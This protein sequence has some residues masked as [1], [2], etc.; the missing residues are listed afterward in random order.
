[1]ANIDTALVWKDS[2]ENLNCVIGY[3]S[4]GNLAFYHLIGSQA[5]HSR[6]SFEEAVSKDLHRSLEFFDLESR[7]EMEDSWNH[8]IED[9]QNLI[10]I[11]KPVTIHV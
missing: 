1:M 3:S 11:E 6:E 7:A 10:R 9:I 5:H 4:E 2:N 8:S